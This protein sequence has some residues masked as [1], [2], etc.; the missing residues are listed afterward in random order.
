MPIV[1]KKRA[2]E[3]PAI[4]PAPRVLA[5][6]AE[7]AEPNRP[8]EQRR[9]GSKRDLTDRVGYRNP[10]K[11]TRFKPGHSGNPKGRPK[12]AKSLQSIVRDTLTQK[13]TI[14]GPFGERKV[15]RIEAILQKAVEQAMKGNPRALAELLKLYGNAVPDELSSPA[16][17]AH[18]EDLTATDLAMLDELR[19]LLNAQ[20]DQRNEP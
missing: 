2:D 6:T 13:V 5:R 7:P 19:V 20:E 16:P 14:R 1:P 11:H 4:H 18:G 3:A 9:K 10:P 12:G 15:S 17:D 8:A